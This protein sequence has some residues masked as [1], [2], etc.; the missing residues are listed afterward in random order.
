MKVSKLQTHIDME[1]VLAEKQGEKLVYVLEATKS[2]ISHAHKDDSRKNGSLILKLFKRYSKVEDFHKKICSIFS[3]KYL[4]P[5]PPKNIYKNEKTEVT[6]RRQINFELFFQTIMLHDEY[7]NHEKTKEFFK[8]E[9]SYSDEVKGNELPIYYL[10]KDVAKIKVP[11]GYETRTKDILEEINKTWFIRDINAFRICFVTE[12]YGEKILDEYE[13]PCQVIET[14]EA[15][16]GSLLKSM[17]G[18]RVTKKPRA[19][20]I[21]YFGEKN[22]MFYMRRIIFH[23]HDFTLEFRITDE[24]LKLR[25]YQALFDL[26]VENILLDSFEDYVDF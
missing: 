26:K 9:Y 14:Y 7:L 6:E 2:I 22:T 24:E 19:N 13:C 8:F 5:I 15:S 12:K 3:G 21:H 10:S 25:Y 1:I 20:I 18:K 16:S 23:P 4:P 11:V 17:I